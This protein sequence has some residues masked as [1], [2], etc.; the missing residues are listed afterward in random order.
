[1]NFAPVHLSNQK[2]VYQQ[3]ASAG[4]SRHVSPSGLYTFQTHG[5]PHPMYSTANNNRTPFAPIRNIN[6]ALQKENQYET[7]SMLMQKERGKNNRS[8]T[9][10]NNH[11]TRDVGQGKNQSKKVTSASNHTLL[12]NKMSQASVDN[13]SYSDIGN[14]ENLEIQ[15]VGGNLSN[16]YQSKDNTQLQHRSTSSCNGLATSYVGLKMLK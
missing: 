7:F 14:L 8:K 16:Y 2:C 1:M 15:T 6:E 11:H 9:H 5:G 10:D 12:A 4:G 13:R 3:P